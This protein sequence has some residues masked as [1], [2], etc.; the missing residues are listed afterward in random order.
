MKECWLSPYGEIIYTNGEWNHASKAAEIILKRYNDGSW[1]DTQDVWC[2]VAGG[3]GSKS[4]SDYLQNKGW[5]RYSTISNN[6]IVGR[7]YDIY[8]TQDQ[9]DKMFELT[10]FIYEEN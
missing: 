7:D 5:I 9:K 4:P 2:G 3:W 10:G 8:P 1:K 6:W